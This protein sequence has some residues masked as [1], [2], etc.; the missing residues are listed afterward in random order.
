MET[1]H[2][3]RAG[4]L[5]QLAA[6]ETLHHRACSIRSGMH[7]SCWLYKPRQVKDECY[8]QEMGRSV[9]AA[10]GRDMHL[11]SWL[12]WHRQV[13]WGD[14]CQEFGRSVLAA[15]PRNGAPPE[16]AQLALRPQLQA[17]P[18]QPA[19]SV[20][21][22]ER[23]VCGHFLMRSILSFSHR[24]AAPSYHCRVCCSHDNLPVQ[25]GVCTS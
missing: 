1:L 8:C 25:T 13:E 14:C 23:Q 24:L 20:S 4:Q 6:I 19:P 15:A 18:A 9:P 21:T 22:D 10:W 12:H 11:R 7:L 5:E 2:N 3:V 16:G 17:D